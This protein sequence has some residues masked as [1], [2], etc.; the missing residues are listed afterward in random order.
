MELPKKIKHWKSRL[1]LVALGILTLT[2]LTPVLAYETD[3]VSKQQ[4]SPGKQLPL[5]ELKLFTEVFQRIKTVYVEPVDDSQLL[6]N[7]LRGMVSELDPHS[8]FLDAEE[9][10]DLQTHTTGEFGG[11]GVKVDI[12]DGF[13]RIISPI[14]DTPAQRAGIQAGDFIIK[15]DGQPVQDMKLT[16]A[17]KKMR[18][19][20]GSKITLTI[21]RESEQAPF[22]VEIIRDIIQVS[23]VKSRMLDE[24]IGYLR[25]SQFQTDTGEEINKHLKRLLKNNMKA[26]VL[27]LRNNPG[28]VLQAAVEAGDVFISE[29]EIV[30]TKGRLPSSEQHYTAT[31]Q[32][33]VPDLP[34]VVLI[35]GGSASASEIVAGALQD[36]KRATI[37]GQNSFGKG[38]VQTILPLTKGRGLKLTTARY[39]TPNGRSIQAQGI[40]PDIIVDNAEIKLSIEDSDFI[41]ESDLNHHLENN[42]DRKDKAVE[43]KESLATQDYQL[44][45]ASNLLKAILVMVSK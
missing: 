36:H 22:D 13:I 31:K 11:L 17:I 26:I 8:T 23:S 33:L 39:Y 12:K 35:N 29:G 30:Y 37:M 2:A 34:M 24:Q 40:K 14:D 16:E 10:A 41:K 32:T 43:Q 21:S 4:P 5:D 45:E 3:S 19:K 18:G 15:L 38:S 27:D 42:I 25:I 6:G 9:F 28:G 20:P 44:Y 1:A 7:A